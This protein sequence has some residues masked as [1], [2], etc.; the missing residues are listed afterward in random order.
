MSPGG[1]GLPKMLE[2]LGHFLSD[3]VATHPIAA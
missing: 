3:M 2:C 1:S